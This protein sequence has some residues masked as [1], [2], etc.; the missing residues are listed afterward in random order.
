MISLFSSSGL[1]QWDLIP[2][3]CRQFAGCVSLGVLDA[4]GSGCALFS[5]RV[6]DNGLF[7]FYQAP[8]VRSWRFFPS[9]TRL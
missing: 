4:A 9:A 6:M 7:H 1:L 5:D 8:F 3:F 2:T